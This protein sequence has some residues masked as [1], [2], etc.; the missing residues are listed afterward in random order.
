MNL[1]KKLLEFYVNSSIHVA[2]AVCALVGVTTVELG[3]EA[4]NVIFCFVFFA[5]ISG[6]NFV[7]FFGVAKFHYQRLAKWL[8]MIQIFSFCSFLL[9][10]FYGVQLQVETLVIVG[11]FAVLTFLYAIPFLK[12][13]TKSL[14]HVEGVKV[15]VIALVWMG[16]TVFLPVIDTGFEMT[17]NVGIMGIQRFA[18]VLVLMLP[19]EIRD[20]RYDPKG[21]QTIPQ[22]IGVKKT[23]QLG[24]F[25]LV[26]I[27]LLE[28]L[29]VDLEYSKLIVLGVVALVTVGFVWKAELNQGRYYS[30]FWVEALPILWLL[31]LLVF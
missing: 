21:L 12:D 2:L 24:L 31:L 3:L 23:K 30:A 4:D 22:K 29:K 16:V 10:C 20:L 11:V 15:Y 5:T 1:S 13:K 27:V 9:L 7:K 26:F 8:K 6:Y 18:Y 14:R 17:T 28:C 25:L 19:F